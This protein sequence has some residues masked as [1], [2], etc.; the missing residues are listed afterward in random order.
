M[1]V[2]LRKIDCHTHV[3]VDQLF[4]LRGHSPYGLDYRSLIEQ[5]ESHG[6]GRVIVFPCVSYFGWEGLEL[7][8]PSGFDDDFSVPYAFENRRML[9]EIHEVNA[10]RADAAIPFVI[11]DPARSQAAQA[12]ALRRLR[13][14]F[15]IC[16]LKIQATVIQAPIRS[17]LG[18]GACLL[19]LA[20]EW[21]IPVLIHSS[22]AA[23]D[24][25]SQASDILDV[26]E[27]WPAVRFCLAHSCRFDV[28]SLQRAL[29]LPN[30]W[31]DCSAHGI[32]CD[33]AVSGLEVVAVPE[34]R[35]SADYARPE[36]V[37]RALY[38]MIPDRLM[39]GSDAPF[40]SFAAA[41]EGR[42]LSLFSTY[43][44]EVNAMSL[45]TEPERMAITRENTLRF[46][47]GR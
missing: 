12:A 6:I 3:G 35:L 45:L 4:Y 28:P 11:V 17:L 5:A 19:E 20:R 34:R 18:D 15:P 29:T 16:G 2:D 1:S 40:Y 44:R 22:I 14:R 23:S 26:A 43:G 10:D 25:W 31:V 27:A 21:N 38:E 42:M 9:S 46:L 8:P 41:H 39:W 24:R 37:L 36:R 30:A 32:H 47:S 33:A 13:E 7:P